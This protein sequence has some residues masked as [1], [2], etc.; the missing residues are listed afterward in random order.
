MMVGWTNKIGKELREGK[1]RVRG[2]RLFS[3]PSLMAHALV[4]IPV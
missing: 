4:I 1:E 3:S 2:K